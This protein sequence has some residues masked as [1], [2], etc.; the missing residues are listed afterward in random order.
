MSVSVGG[1][2]LMSL[3]NPFAE[4]VG[5]VLGKTDLRSMFCLIVFFIVTSV[6]A[7]LTN[8]SENSFRAYLTEQSFRQHLSRLDDNGD[9][10]HKR[11]SS[12]STHPAKRATYPTAHT[13][14]CDNSSP[15]H[16]ANRASISLR[17]PKHVF[18]SF[19][20][21]TIAAMVPLA[22]T[23]RSDERQ[24]LIIS[25]SWYVGA[26]GRWWRGGIIEAWYQDVIARTKDEEGWSS[27]ILS[28]K[29][30]D[31]LTEYN[32][33]PFSTKNLPPHL[34][35]QGSPPKLRNRERSTQKPATLPA[36]SSTP[37]PLPKSASLPLHS[38][39]LPS[40]APDRP[41]LNPT[42]PTL[43]PHSCL[44]ADQVRLGSPLLSRSPSTLFDQSPRIAEILRQ[45]T[46]S[47]DAVLDLRTQLNDCQTCASQS[48][49]VLQGEVNCFRERKRQEDAAKL[50]TKSRTKVLDDSRRTVESL[51]RDA[52]KKLKAAQNA[53]DNAT[54]RMDHLD[55]EITRLHERLVKD[56]ELIHQ[57]EETTSEAE[58]EIALALEQKKE[59]IKVAEDVVAALNQR[60][61]ELEEKLAEE[62]ERLTLLKERNDA[63]IQELSSHPGQDF[64]HPDTAIPW[65]PT[66]PY[67]AAPQDTA[68]GPSTPEIR[69]RHSS[70]ASFEAMSGLGRRL[71]ISIDT[72]VLSGTPTFK[73]SP[74][75]MYN[76]AAATQAALRANGYS[77]FDDSILSSAPQQTPYTAFSPFADLD[78]SQPNVVSP[79]SQSLIPSSLITSLENG[80]G[81][82]RSFQSE[83]DVYMDREWRN[84]NSRDPSFKQSVRS[85]SNDSQDHDISTVTTSPISSHGFSSNTME[86]DPFEVR[87]MN[88]DE[89]RRDHGQEYP[90]YQH[91]SS[92]QSMDMQRAS[93]SHRSNSD[94][95]PSFYTQE[96]ADEEPAPAVIAKT[97]PRRWFQ[98]ATKEKPKKGLNPDAKVFSL[99]RSPPPRTFVGPIFNVSPSGNSTTSAYDALN[100]NGLSST[101]M[102]AAASVTNSFT[103]AFAPSPAEREA[104][105]RA[106]GG[107]TNTSYER[108]PSLSDV[109]SIPSSPP[110]VNAAVAR[111]A[112]SKVL[113]AWLQALPRRK[114]NFSPWDDE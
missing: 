81:L 31:R 24:H 6:L 65:S 30:L 60:A 110:H 43:Q 105:Q 22:R 89:Y 7:Y 28:M 96:E 87:F 50:E 21:F 20:L 71:S 53:R 42:Q 97:G 66:A 18:H 48:H 36:R 59:E 104:L 62:K 108:L 19:G 44:A 5:M 93:W 41:P 76:D 27:G 114:A 10:D 61:R 25:D 113:P 75:S 77:V 68:N 23:A 1:L 64:T 11:Q 4:L 79:T 51:K 35:S 95:H 54:Q 91:V 39:R 29:N 67:D 13:L 46:N 99:D 101:A 102:P 103:R 9:D 37:P 90:T 88:E 56:E 17:T 100:P 73:S 69:E 86:H 94:P 47:K 78:G 107:S 15:F 40:T 112:L 111:H 34:L 16:F 26:F 106:L 70:G 2:G 74:T 14:S 52:E 38:A 92:E 58:K 72:P 83:S 32:G 8:P 84:N 57:S 98:S 33:L 63:R 55:K 3:R 12:S 85:R 82:P 80:I 45:I 109:G 49:S